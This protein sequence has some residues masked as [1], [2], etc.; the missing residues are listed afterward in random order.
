MLGLLLLLAVAAVVCVRLGVWQLDRAQ[1]H[2]AQ[3]EQRRVAALVAADP[4]PLEQVLAPQTAFT[5][6]LVGRKVEVTGTYDAAGQ[7]LVAGRVHEGV[8]GSLVLTPLS[9]TVDGEQAVLPVVRG[10]TADPGSAQPPP[11][12]TVRLIGYLQAGEAPTGTITDGRTEAISPAQLLSAWGGP[13][14]TGYLVLAESTPAQTGDLALLDVPSRAGSGL[15]L[16]NLAYAAQ[17]WIFAG[18]A[19]VVWWRTVRDEARYGA[20]DGAAVP[21]PSGGGTAG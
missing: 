19:L 11:T 3:A 18:F 10:W 8:T 5:G 2:G 4:A 1:V 16:Q 14:W 15:N 21:P 17:W 12:G 6:G 9:V 20:R 13:I 7:L